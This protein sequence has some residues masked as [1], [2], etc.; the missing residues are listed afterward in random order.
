MFSGDKLLGGPQGG[1]IV[2]RR[3]SIDKLMRHPLARAVRLDKASIAGLAATLRIYL[4][5]RALEAIP[6]WRMMAMPLDVIL[7]RANSIASAI[8]RASLAEGRSMIGGGS[9]PEE[10]L[11]TKLVALDSERGANTVAGRLRGGGVVARVE[12]GRVLLDPRTIR[13]DEDTQLI[14]ACRAAIG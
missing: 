14:E 10:S 6:V 4:E 13:P 3:V 11:P 7:A 9:L 5:G 12:D 2:G 8:G 1:L